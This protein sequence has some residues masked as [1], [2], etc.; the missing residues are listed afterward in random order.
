MGIPR[1]FQ[2]LCALA[3]SKRVDL[4]KRLLLRTMR[5][6]WPLVPH[7]RRRLKAAGL[8]PME[9]NRLDQFQKLPPEA[10]T[11][12]L[13]QPE[14]Q[15]I[16]QPDP[17]RIRH[18]WGWARKL[19]LVLARGKGGKLLQKGYEASLAD[20][21]L[22]PGCVGAKVHSSVHDEEL[23]GQQGSRCL[24]LLGIETGPL[25]LDPGAKI[26]VLT[27]RALVGGARLLGVEL[28]EGSASETAD[29][30]AFF[31]TGPNP[32]G[33]KGTLVRLDPMNSD[34]PGILTLPT[35]RLVL[36]VL[37]DGAGAVL[38]DDLV[39]AEDLP[40][41]LTFTHLAHHGTMLARAVLPS[42]SQWNALAPSPADGPQFPRLTHRA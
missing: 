36:P 9:L 29:G 31:F 38:W 33:A 15:L 3:P 8:D 14:R 1:S 11:H 6:E 24:L 2:D 20:P 26:P 30:G 32:T 28:R 22:D 25:V 12:A 42:L 35:A 23:L 40:E 4:G 19:G 39:W 18:N 13:R 27:R 17:G 16:P 41:G 34:A 37:G 5:E 10:L 7:L 21:L